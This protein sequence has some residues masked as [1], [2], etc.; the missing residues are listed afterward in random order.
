[1]H[2]LMQDR[3]D[4]DKRRYKRRNRIE[5]VSVRSDRTAAR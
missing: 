1:M 5:I 2:P 4:A 3:N